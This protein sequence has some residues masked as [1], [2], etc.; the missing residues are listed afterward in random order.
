MLL[1][2]HVL[3]S[4]SLLFV[5]EKNKVMEPAFYQFT[6]NNFQKHLMRLDNIV[7]NALDSQLLECILQSFTVMLLLF[8]FIIMC[9]AA[10][11]GHMT[12]HKSH[13]RNWQK[14]KKEYTE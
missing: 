7:N 1:L 11:N 5:M 4:I 8:F 10:C 2:V 6:G 3:R 9:K 14:K 12:R 13:D